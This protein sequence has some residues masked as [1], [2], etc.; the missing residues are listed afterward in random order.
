MTD[1]VLNYGFTGRFQ[2]QLEPGRVLAAHPAPTPLK[3]PRAQIAAA[4]TQPLEYPPL[5]QCVIPG[6]RIVLVLERHVP[7]AVEL[8]AEVWAALERRGVQPADVTILH[9]G[10]YRGR[11]P[12]DPR[13]A[14]PDAVRCEI[15]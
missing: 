15:E 4:L 10:D 3:Q 1:Q 5:D 7:C 6:D 11:S 8:I 14:L 9:P 2:F 13:N 12:L